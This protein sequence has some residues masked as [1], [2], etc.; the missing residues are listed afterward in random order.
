MNG[1]DWTKSF[2]NHESLGLGESNLYKASLPKGLGNYENSEA[3]D[4]GTQSSKIFI[5]SKSDGSG[6]DYTI[7]LTTPSSYTGDYGNN[8]RAYG[9]GDTGS[10]VVK[11]ND[12][13]VVNASLKDNFIN[14][15]K[16]ASQDLTEYDNNGFE[17]GTASFSEGNLVLNKVAPFNNV[18]Q[19]IN[20]DNIYYPNGY[21]AWNATLTINQKIQNGYNKVE[22][23][24]RIFPG[25]TH[26]LN[27]VD[28]Y[29]DDGLANP[30][31]DSTK[32]I[33]WNE[34]SSSPT[35]SLSGISYFIKNTDFNLS[36]DNVFLNL[37]NKTYRQ[38]DNNA[39]IAYTKETSSGHIDITAGDGSPSNQSILYFELNNTENRNGLVINPQE[40]F[41]IPSITSTGS[42][43]NIRVKGTGTINN[44]N[45]L[46]TIRGIEF[47][48]Y[49][50]DLSSND[51]WNQGDSFHTPIGRFIS[52][53]GSDSGNLIENFDKETFR[54]QSSSVTDNYLEGLGSDFSLFTSLLTGTI[55]SADSIVNTGELQQLI[56][57]ELSYPITQDYIGLNPNSINYN[58]NFN[59]SFPVRHYFRA[60]AF[61]FTNNTTVNNAGFSSNINL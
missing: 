22:F 3:L 11:I 47:G 20:N 54:L 8:N 27:T 18:S 39:Y 33:T 42:V 37:A 21:Q 52:S 4:K 15:S 36:I 28:W 9:H 49:N 7:T 1:N 10:L 19:S 35:H 25:V 5:T 16:S 6:N 41:I 14:T 26:S 59:T 56:G 58:V 53:V 23:E 51:T 38:A 13:E 61:D 2:K 29:Y 31:V 60:F 17:N 46:G 34:Y 32:T 48:V 50:R 43:T 45:G 44:N 12:S 57:G 24:H 30:Q 55:N 40:D